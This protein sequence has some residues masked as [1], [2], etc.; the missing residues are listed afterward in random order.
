MAAQLQKNLPIGISDFKK[1]VDKARNY[2]FID[3]SLFIKAVLDDGSE[4]VLITRP[5][6]W[7]KT[8]SVSMLDYFLSENDNLFDDLA[9]AK[10]DDGRYRAYRGKNPVIFVSFK[11]VKS[12]Q[13]TPSVE[14]IN[15]LIQSVFR[16]HKTGLLNSDLLDEDDKR[17]F[18]QYLNGAASEMQ[19]QNALLVLTEMLRKHYGEKVYILIDE[20]DTPLNYA[21]VHGYLDEMTEFMKN[22]L[23]AGLKDNPYLEKGVMT[24]ILR[25]SKDSMLSGLNNLKVF[26][27]LND[28]RFDAYFGFCESEVKSLF[29]A[30]SVNYSEEVRHYYNGYRIHDKEFYNPWSI[31]EC[32]SNQGK[33]EPYWV[34]TSDNTLLKHALLNAG[35]AIKTEIQRFVCDKKYVFKTLV[36]KS[37]RF[38]DIREGGNTLWGLMLAM[39]YLTPHSVGKPIG[40]SYPCELVIPNEE[41][42]QLYISIFQSWLF[43]KLNT[44]DYLIFLEDLTSGRIAEFTKKLRHYL[45][46][47]GSF[48]D[49]K[50]ES[51][52]HTFLLGLLCSLSPDYWIHSNAETG[53]GRADLILVPKD[54]AKS[55]AIIIE[56]K[57]EKKAKPSKKLATA[58]LKQIDTRQY[59]AFIAQHRAIE[60]TLKIGLVFNGKQVNSCYRWDDCDDNPLTEA[61][62]D[63]EQQ[64]NES[65]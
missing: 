24:G 53:F 11:D 28:D 27:I 9:I 42:R 62:C 6:R 26:S 58:A 23:S 37:S 16:K 61:V 54:T 2:L 50:D 44:S 22:F 10:V 63:F 17:V 56:L 21:S 13:F 34:D 7:G 51:N 48:Y 25:V 5:R 47:H 29:N 18:N 32:L 4:A 65:E 8:L 60:K 12:D 15:H 35:M 46:V 1:L 3:K 64:A 33:L 55:F 39:G 57:H 41:V 36:P 45:L 38:E 49:F 19:L 52:Y 30:C 20:Y 40:L 59:A 31:I 43:E 14:K